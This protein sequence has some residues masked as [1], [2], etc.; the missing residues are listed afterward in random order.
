[1]IDEIFGTKN[2]VRDELFLPA[3]DKDIRGKYINKMLHY[4]HQQLEHASSNYGKQIIIQEDKE[5]SQKERNKLSKFT[6]RYL[7]SDFLKQ[8]QNEKHYKLV[9][10]VIGHRRFSII[11]Y[12]VQNISRENYAKLLKS[13]WLWLWIISHNNHI[14]CT[15][16]LEITMAFLP[17]KK[18]IALD[19][20][21]TNSVIG[22]HH[23]N[24]ALTYVCQP[25]NT[26]LIYRYEECFKV[27]IHESFHNFGLDFTMQNNEKIHRELQEMFNINKNIDLAAYESYT[28]FW[29]EIINLV[30]IAYF[31]S[32]DFSTFSLSFYTMLAL[33][34]RYSQMQTAKLLTM[35][36]SDGADFSGLKQKS[37]VFEYYVMKS[38]LMI[39]INA[40]LEV[41]F[42]TN[43]LFFKINKNTD[44]LDFVKKHKKT[45]QHE[46]IRNIQ[47]FLKKLKNLHFSKNSKS[48]EKGKKDKKDE[49]DENQT[50][51]EKI[52]KTMRMTLFDH[53]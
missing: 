25:N 53:I 31:I 50:I 21:E 24:S 3:L 27:F 4:F 18:V 1:M 42:K 52:M 20:M 11:F 13:M 46:D 2:K 22:T 15:Q 43:T 38:I 7:P 45:L 30:F 44:F 8:L 14:K 9:H 23:V 47:L 36:D 26:M 28:E 48:L 51:Y 16:N 49:K 40:F 34:T 41:C 39:N 6:S 29:G 32:S 33:E 35:I 5:V 19:E 12:L 37:H 10:F 17:D